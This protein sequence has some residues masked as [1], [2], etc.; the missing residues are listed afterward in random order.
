MVF[1]NNFALMFYCNRFVN[2]TY[3]TLVMGGMPLLDMDSS[4]LY[5]SPILLGPIVVPSQNLPIL[6]F[7]GFPEIHSPYM[8]LDL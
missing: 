2:N 8:Q 4:E 7:Q 6:I 1:D 3:K 5:L